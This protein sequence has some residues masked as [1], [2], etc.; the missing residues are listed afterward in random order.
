MPDI[1]SLDE[2]LHGKPE[3]HPM[4]YAYT[5]ELYPGL[6]KVG[7]TAIDV[8]ARVAQQYPT[9]RPDG[10][11]PYRIVLRESAMYSDGG[12][13]SDHDVHR[14]LRQ[15][16]VENPGGEWFR[17]DVDKVKAAVVAIRNRTTPEALDRTNDFSMRPEQEQA[18][19]QTMAYFRSAYQAG[20]RKTPKF[21][22][23]AKMRFGKTF[24]S[25]ELARKMGLKR[26]LILTFKPAVKTAWRDDLLT[27]KNYVGW[28][29]ITR[30]ENPSEPDINQQYLAADKSK[31]IVC[32]GSFQDFLGY[33]KAT[34]GYKPQHEWVRAINW[35]LVIFDEYHFG[36]W[37]ENA[38]A[39]FAYDEDTYEED[40]SNY[41][42]SDA[43][44]ENELP[45]TTDYYLY[46]SGTPFRALRLGEFVEDQLFTWTYS[47]EQKAKEEWPKLSRFPNYVPK[48]GEKNP[49]AALP[50][51]V[52]LTYKIPESIQR[53]AK[54]TDQDEFG[55]NVFFKAEGK[56]DEA[57]FVNEEYVQKWLDL[58]RGAYNETTVDELRMGAKKPPMPFSDVTLRSELL[59][60]VWFMPSVASC[61]A[62]R[63]LLAKT[64]N[65]FYHDYTVNVCAGIGA[66]IG[67]SALDPVMESMGD[68]LTNKTITLTC[69]KLMTGVTVKPW[70][71]ILMLRDLSSPETY[72]QAA[73]RVQ[74]P[75]EI[76]GEN[77]A[78]E[79]MKHD[80]Y[81]F[82][83][84]LNRALKQIQEY[85]CELNT[86]E[87]SPER[88]V[89]EFIRF[90][91]VLAYEGSHMERFD[92]SKILDF[93]MSGT[94]ATLL[95]KR[96]QAAILVNVD[97]DTL[98]RLM[99]NEQAMAALNK[100]EAFRNLNKDIP[101]I[102]NRS[103]A[104]KNIKKESDKL[105][106]KKKKEL[107]DEQKE[108]KNKRKEIRN[109]L[110]KFAA[111]IPIFMFL[112]DYREET[113]QDVITEIEPNLFRKVTGLDVQDFDLLCSLN[114]FNAT[115]M[116]DAVYKFWRYE[117]SSLNYTGVNKHAGEKV[118]LYSTVL[119]REE[120]EA[121]KNVGTREEYDHY[122]DELAASMIAAIPAD[123]DIPDKP[124]EVEPED[125][126]DFVPEP[127][128]EKP[129][130][131]RNGNTIVERYQ[132][133]TIITPRRAEPTP[134]PAPAPA[135]PQPAPV[136]IELPEIHIGTVAKHRFFG[137]GTI[138]EINEA[139]N[140][141]Y[142]RF[143]DQVKPFQLTMAF[144]KGMLEIEE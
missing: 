30:P 64:H 140:R 8:D 109:Q 137:K 71:G 26:V 100:I 115:T 69:G 125:E 76:E 68:P 38:K 56:G 85:S 111:R 92:A 63:N 75:W 113:L 99:A 138:T 78:K 65:T 108:I 36:A 9:R 120:Y 24:A 117:E 121:M 132:D 45:I 57:H 135:A 25:Y 62:M 136:E 91:P 37:K 127:V 86:G 72:F 124:F 35:D 50:R 15:M 66:G 129:R 116:N 67:A 102:I 53:I 110:L 34:N 142:V 3:A 131:R 48:P 39:M 27:H 31:P 95:A 130:K 144:A 51:M 79:V 18:V 10:S 52:M 40:L 126:D 104:I 17:C 134:A 107:D 84:A 49:Y 89:A 22:W 19:N 139:T 11:V 96:W 5:D 73:F 83:F 13:F 20:S 128:A 7:Y 118:G 2:F 60:T 114:V 4:I 54:E 74:S 97:N 61:F 23:N 21:L 133:V 42:Q 70:S 93:A 82:D 55:L 29:F 33:N 28:Q 46:L 41:S 101:A 1:N 77:G 94:T 81:V 141:L 32:F 16:G 47:D 58:I 106:P 88:K 87:R 103:E 112:T 59:H 98:R 6:L 143:G 14:L 44:N 105:T 123:D 122:A 43:A 80:C 119:S 90:L 12:S